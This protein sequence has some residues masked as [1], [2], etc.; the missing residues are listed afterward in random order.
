MDEVVDE[1]ENH[2][3]YAAMQAI[4]TWCYK[5]LKMPV[6]CTTMVKAYKCFI[7]IDKLKDVEELIA[8]I[9]KFVCIV[10]ECGCKENQKIIMNDDIFLF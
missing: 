2:K 8:R 5:L 7:T 9:D 4:S 3:R 1:L 6:K 10:Q